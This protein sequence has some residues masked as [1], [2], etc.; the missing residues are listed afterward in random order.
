V[1]DVFVQPRAA[2]EGIVGV[3]GSA[4]KLKVRAAPA[5]GKANRA[6]EGLL[7]SALSV[8]PSA[9]TVISGHSSRSKRVE[10]AS[11]TVDSVACELARVLSSSAHDSG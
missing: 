1:I 8:P 4:L 10:V 2:K 7:A 3:H 11:A 9:V 5:D 6:A